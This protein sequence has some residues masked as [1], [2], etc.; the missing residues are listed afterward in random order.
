MSYRNNGAHDDLVETRTYVPDPIPYPSNPIVKYAFKA[1]VWGWRLGLGPLAGRLFLILTTTGR[2]SGLPR[3][4][5]LEY[6]AWRGRMYVFSAWGDRA[7]WYKNILTDPRVTLQTAHGTE[8]AVARRLT[9]ADELTEAFGFVERH[10]F[11]R[12]WL[13]LLGVEITL[14]EFITHRERYTLLTFDATDEPTPA[15]QSPDLVWVWPVLGVIL[16]LLWQLTRRR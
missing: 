12:R 15:P 11:L 4:T 1:P 8:P 16:V 9:A 10:R 7:Q 3:R 14:D 2:S 6:F 5:A 13:D